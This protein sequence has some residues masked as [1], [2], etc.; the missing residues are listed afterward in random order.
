MSDRD[1][2]IEAAAAV[3]AY[4]ATCEMDQWSLDDVADL[5]GRALRTAQQAQPDAADGEPA[6]HIPGFGGVGGAT[7]ANAVTPVQPSDGEPTITNSEI[8]D[9]LE[10]GRKL[11]IEARRELAKLLILDSET[12][13]LR[14]GD[15]EPTPDASGEAQLQFDGKVD[16]ASEAALT[17]MKYKREMLDLDM[18]VTVE[19]DAAWNDLANRLR[20][21]QLERD[22]LAGRVGELKDA[23]DDALHARI[24]WVARCRA[25]LAGRGGEDKGT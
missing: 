9:L 7:G 16:P 25:A 18:P 20:T 17:W 13:G 6:I 4:A 12:L 10:E 3:L 11:G 21:V 19:V 22:A 14:F 24:R 15:G 23:I 2:L 8:A 5:M 1:A